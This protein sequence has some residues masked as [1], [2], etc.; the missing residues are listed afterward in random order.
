VRRNYEPVHYLLVDMAGVRLPSSSS[1][2]T[3]DAASGVKEPDALKTIT[4][5]RQVVQVNI[6]S[7][8][9]MGLE[10]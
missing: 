9:V 6:F 10:H 2:A 1:S 3:M 5:S 7:R 8:D 4:I